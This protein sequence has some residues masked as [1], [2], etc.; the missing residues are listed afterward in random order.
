MLTRN[1][2]TVQDARS[3]FAEIADMP[4]PLVGFK[5]IG[6]PS[7][8]LRAL[9]NDIRSNGQEVMLEVVSERRE[10]ELKSIRAGLEIGVDYILGGTNVEEASQVLA[11]SGVTYMPFPGRIVGHPSKLCG[12]PEEI[13]ESA[14]RLSRHPGVGGLDL[15]AYRYSGNVEALIASVLDSVSCPV[16]VAG[17][18]AS[19]ER[20]EIVCGLGA[21][22]FTVGSAV[23]DKEFAGEKSLRGQLAAILAAV[24]STRPSRRQSG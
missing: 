9:A 5:D 23:F 8:E 3:V 4:I 10:D 6:L 2:A 24:E 19:A 20:I 11:G 15:L 18:I 17:S 13:V 12:S 14:R 16:V 1:D 7:A 22:G 21:W